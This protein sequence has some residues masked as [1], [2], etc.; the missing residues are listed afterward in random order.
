MTK[1]VDEVEITAEV[2]KATPAEV[3]ELANDLEPV[4]PEVTDAEV[5]A[6]IEEGEKVEVTSFTDIATSQAEGK[7]V[8]VTDDN[9]KA[10]LIWGFLQENQIDP[11]II[12]SALVHI[13]ENISIVPEGISIKYDENVKLMEMSS[14][15][16]AHKSVEVDA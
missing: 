1:K 2:Q 6:L 15:P 12:L 9:L 10:S 13:T 11:M 16:V 8:V 3:E 5:Q 14:T 7:V 4:K